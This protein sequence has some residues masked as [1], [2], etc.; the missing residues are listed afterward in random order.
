M[1]TPIVRGNRTTYKVKDYT[2]VFSNQK[3]S[4]LQGGFCS[5]KMTLKN[6]PVLSFHY[7]YSDNRARLE[8][9]HIANP[10]SIG[11]SSLAKELDLMM[12]LLETHLKKQGL[13]FTSVSTHKGFA[14]FL[15]QRK[16][17]VSQK[18]NLSYVL[19]KKL[20]QRNNPLPG[21]LGGKWR[22]RKLKV[23]NKLR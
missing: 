13:T 5:A 9:L 3:P 16:W 17:K 23:R 20:T 11:T 6:K 12:H 15:L 21:I 14:K 10:S 4:G 2:L 7:C 18:N 8:D 19:E 22:A 1:I